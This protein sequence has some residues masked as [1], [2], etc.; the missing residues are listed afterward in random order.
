MSFEINRFVRIFNKDSSFRD[1][2]GFKETV[3]VGSYRWKGVNTKSGDEDREAELQAEHRVSK[4]GGALFVDH[5][6]FV[7]FLEVHFGRR[8]WKA[9]SFVKL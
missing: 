9:K 3:P 6:L 7:F 5:E 4:C 2:I 8:R 1:L